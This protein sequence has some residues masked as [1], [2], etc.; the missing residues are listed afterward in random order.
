LR[1]EIGIGMATGEVVAGCMGSIDRLNYTVLGAKVNLAARLASQAGAGE[2][3]I[4]DTTLAAL[5]PEFRVESLGEIAIRGFSTP[6]V[7]YRL[8][9]ATARVKHEEPVPIG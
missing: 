7:A 2:V 1:L 9:A 4:D 5:G 8:E 3:I 6:Q